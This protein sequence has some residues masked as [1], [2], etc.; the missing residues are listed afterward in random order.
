MAWRKWKGKLELMS[1]IS[2]TNQVSSVHYRQSSAEGPSLEHKEK[3][4]ETQRATTR[5]CGN[6][7]PNVK[8]SPWPQCWFLG[9]SSLFPGMSSEAPAW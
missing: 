6:G 2:S 5:P 7:F 8:P 3:P 4:Q 9:H 1:L